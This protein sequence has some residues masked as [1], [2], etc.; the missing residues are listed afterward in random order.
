MLFEVP[1]VHCHKIGVH[2][3]V[4]AKYRERRHFTSVR[5][6]VKLRAYIRFAFVFEIM[7][8]VVVVVELYLSTLTPSTVADFHGGRVPEN[9]FTCRI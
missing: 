7:L 2:E 5:Y 1:R 6:D 8:V 3:Q 4:S 9:Y